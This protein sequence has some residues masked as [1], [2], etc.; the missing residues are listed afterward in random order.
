MT[1]CSQAQH[2]Q[3]R[4][5][6]H[7]LNE[8]M[9]LANLFLSI[10]IVATMFFLVVGGI[11]IYSGEAVSFLFAVFAS[12]VFSVFAAWV[13]AAK[14]IHIKNSKA[15]RDLFVHMREMYEYADLSRHFISDKDVLLEKVVQENGRTIVVQY[16]VAIHPKTDLPSL[17]ALVALRHTGDYHFYFTMREIPLLTLFKTHGCINHSAHWTNHG[18]VDTID[19]R[20]VMD[21]VFDVSDVFNEKLARLL[22]HAEAVGVLDF[23]GIS[24]ASMRSILVAHPGLIDRLADVDSQTLLDWSRAHLSHYL[25]EK[26]SFSEGNLLSEWITILPKMAKDHNFRI[27]S[28]IAEKLGEY[29]LDNGSE[30][31]I[32]Y[33]CACLSKRSFIPMEY[34]HSPHINNSWLLRYAGHCK[35][36]EAGLYPIVKAILIKYPPQDDI[37]EDEALLVAYK[38][39]FG[40]EQALSRYPE[41]KRLFIEHDFGV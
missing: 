37:G 6:Q 16:S 12:M 23:R 26:K 30:E 11:S 5:Q 27:P 19:E 33:F 24:R 35:S 3:D 1:I 40:I 32:C 21:L 2:Q 29:C 38:D 25:D 34:Y 39:I 28:K 14:R 4:L 13:I 18:L 20:R 10:A 31:D 41:S 15:A 36:N 9:T 7:Y 8:Q 22:S 17:V